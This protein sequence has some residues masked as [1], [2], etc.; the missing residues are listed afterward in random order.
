MWM[1]IQLRQRDNRTLRSQTGKAMPPDARPSQLRSPERIWKPASACS[2]GQQ[3]SAKYCDL[4]LP[5]GTGYSTAHQEPGAN[6]SIALRMWPALTWIR[7]SDPSCQN[8]K[9]TNAAQHSLHWLAAR[10]SH[11]N[12]VSLIASS[13]A[14]P[15][16]SRRYGRRAA[17]RHWRM[18]G[19]Y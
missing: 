14:K 1:E 17:G 19:L 11:S 3:T 13:H 2:C 6:F 10:C 5:L 15:R 9:M 4:I 8:I 7:I 12:H 16:Q 18:G